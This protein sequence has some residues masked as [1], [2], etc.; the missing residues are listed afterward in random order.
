MCTLF[1]VVVLQGATIKQSKA[2]YS[3]ASKLPYDETDIHGNNYNYMR[4]LGVDSDEVRVQLT[5]EWSANNT[6]YVY[7]L[8]NLELLRLV[9]HVNKA[10]QA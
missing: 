5:R 10:A 3:V 7:V 1:A 8:Q 6:C 9:L 4:I 2:N